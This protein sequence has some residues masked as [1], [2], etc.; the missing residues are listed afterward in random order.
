MQGM[1]RLIAIRC[2]KFG[3]RSN[4]EWHQTQRALSKEGVARLEYDNWAAH[5]I[6]TPKQ[7]IPW[8]LAVC[9]D[10]RFP[11]GTNDPGKSCSL[12]RLDG[13]LQIIKEVEKPKTN[14]EASY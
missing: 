5:C 1:K 2:Q 6:L 4:L 13:A 12:T 11:V 9:K 7:R 14:L 8:K 3:L 10:N